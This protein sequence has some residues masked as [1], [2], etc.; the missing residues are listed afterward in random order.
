MGTLDQYV[1]HRYKSV[2]SEHKTVVF[3]RPKDLCFLSEADV[4]VP[5]DVI[6]VP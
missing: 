2:D 1:F 5:V 4:G 3:E 6:A